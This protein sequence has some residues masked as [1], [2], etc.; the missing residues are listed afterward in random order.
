MKVIQESQNQMTLRLRPWFLWI[1]CSILGSSGLIMPLFIAHAHTF[2]CRRQTSTLGTCQISI[3]GLLS[4]TEKEIALSDIQG[5]EIKTFK[6]SKDNW[7]SQVILLTKD[8]EVPPIANTSPNDVTVKTWAKEIEAFLQDSQKQ[9][10]LIEYDYRL[11]A[12]LYASVFVIADLLIVIFLGKVLICHIDKTL[13]TLTLEYQGLFDKSQKEYKIRDIQFMTV[14][15]T[16]SKSGSTY[17]VAMVM[18]SG[19]QIPFTSYYTSGLHNKQKTVEN[20]SR[21]LDL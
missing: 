7:R 19:E 3:V 21:F 5:T 20:I 2:S 10:L 12:Y 14:Q 15:K 9:E 16:S 4:K 8:G 11:L 17:R 6:D 13:G 1:F 18:Q